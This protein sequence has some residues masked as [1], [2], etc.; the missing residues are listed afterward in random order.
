MSAVFLER[1][2]FEECESD[3]TMAPK[4]MTFESPKHLSCLGAH[5]VIVVVEQFDEGPR[6]VVGGPRGPEICSEHFRRAAADR[7]IWVS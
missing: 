1:P 6:T 5:A 4:V 2:A 7:R 3:V